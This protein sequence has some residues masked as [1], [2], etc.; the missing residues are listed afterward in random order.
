METMTNDDICIFL[1]LLVLFLFTMAIF[2]NIAAIKYTSVDT[3]SFWKWS[4]GKHM[5]ELRIK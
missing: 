1:L 2:F 5:V 3:M 4:I